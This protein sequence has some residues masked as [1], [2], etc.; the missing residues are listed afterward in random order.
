MYRKS[1][2]D[3]VWTTSVR[4]QR[5]PT[6]SAFTLKVQRL[7]FFLSVLCSVR[8]RWMCLIVCGTAMPLIR[9]AFPSDSS[10]PRLRCCTFCPS[11]SCW[12]AAAPATGSSEQIAPRRPPPP[13]RPG[14]WWHSWFP[15]WRSCWSD[16]W[17][18]DFP[19]NLI[20]RSRTSTEPTSCAAL[21]GPAC[22]RS[23]S[24]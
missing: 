7:M 15:L 10:C 18:G 24:T 9:Q 11:P 22:K 5:V 1:H 4:C 14:R 19:P 23:Y 2:Y 8:S 3:Y 20:D 12:C 6:R 21:L 17:R 13:P 16:C